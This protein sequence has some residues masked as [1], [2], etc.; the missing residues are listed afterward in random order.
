MATIYLSIGSNYQ[1]EKNIIAALHLLQKQ[2]GTLTVSPIYRSTAIENNGDD[3]FNLV[4]SLQSEDDVETLRRHLRRVEA[5]LERNRDEP[6]RVSIDIDLLLYDNFVGTAA[7]YELPHPDIARYRHVSQ[8]LADLAPD[9][10]HPTL[11]KTYQAISDE[12]VGE[13]QRVTIS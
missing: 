10:L 1:R 5:T 8:P 11:L 3:Y 12:V 13:L 7:G 2:F 6:Q 9:S 4:V